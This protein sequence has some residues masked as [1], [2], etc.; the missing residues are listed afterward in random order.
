M[1]K[2]ACVLA[3]PA[4]A[5]VSVAVAQA[6]IP[7]PGGLASHRLSQDVDIKQLPAT[8]SPVAE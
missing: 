4:L 2:R 5:G 8:M 7:V 1:P 3:P 6:S